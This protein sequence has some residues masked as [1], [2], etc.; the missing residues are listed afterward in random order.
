MTKLKPTGRPRARASSNH[1]CLVRPDKNFPDLLFQKIKNKKQEI[2]NGGDGKLLVL[3]FSL[4]LVYQLT[5][6]LVIY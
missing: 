1:Y 6:L 2:R 4:V 5:C 3:V